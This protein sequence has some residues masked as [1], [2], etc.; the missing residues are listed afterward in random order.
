MGL[1][2]NLKNK[3]F[4]LAGPSIAWLQTALR[5]MEA[6]AEMPSPDYPCLTF[7]GTDEKIVDPDNIKQRMPNWSNGTLEIVESG[8]H[9]IMMETASMRDRFFAKTAQHFGL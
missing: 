5:E 2:R 3:D 9:E 6:L 1:G 7:L 8:K 4:E